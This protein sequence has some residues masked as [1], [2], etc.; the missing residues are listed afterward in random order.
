M[1][2]NR[3]LT[4]RNLF[5]LAVARSLIEK[6]EDDYQKVLVRL[7]GMARRDILVRDRR[8]HRCNR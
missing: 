6:T 7:A 5:Y 4:V 8:R 2:E 1:M 3:P